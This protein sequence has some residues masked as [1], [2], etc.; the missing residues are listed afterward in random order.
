MK[1]MKSVARRV[2]LGLTE[3]KRFAVIN[4]NA[5]LVLG[6]GGN[7]W[8]YR[9]IFSR[10]DPGVGAE[11]Y[12]GNEI[13]NPLLKLKF[14]C[15]ANWAD[16]ALQQP[17][18]YGT[19]YFNVYLVASNEQLPQTTFANYASI[20][21]DP[22]W[23]YSQV[24]SKPT[25]NGN[26]VKVLKRWRKSITPDVVNAGTILGRKAITGQMTYRWKR[27]LKF[28]DDATIPTVGGPV[29]T[30]VLRGWN[31]YILA[32]FGM[33]VSL[34]GTFTSTPVIAMDSF[35]YFKDP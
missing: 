19:I 35:L 34:S 8:S 21:P 24:S 33:P 10:L 31:Y 16:I 22:G 9:N 26:N 11:N 6:S 23:F 5:T 25:L 30:R 20:S 4:E 18:Q 14:V 3:S 7:Q 32:G 17:T 28:E 12:I 2:T 27:K 1:M 15:L 13:A 29:N